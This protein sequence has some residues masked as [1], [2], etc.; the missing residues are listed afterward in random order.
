MP[1]RLAQ[2]CETFR[3]RGPKVALEA[4]EQDFSSELSSLS[5]SL[6]SNGP[7][8]FHGTLDNVGKR[9]ESESS[10][11]QSAPPSWL[12]F[13]VPIDSEL[14][15]YR[16]NTYRFCSRKA[17]L[18]FWNHLALGETDAVRRFCRDVFKVPGTAGIAFE[19]FAHFVLTRTEHNTFRWKQYDD[20]PEDSKNSE[21]SAD[22]V[23]L[24]RCL[25]QKCG[26]KNN[27]DSFEAAIKDCIS[28][29]KSVVID[30]IS[31]QQDAIDMFVVCKLDR[32]GWCVLAM[33]DTISKTHSFHP[34]KILEYR[35]AAEKAF[36]AAKQEVRDDFFLHVVV[37]PEENVGKPFRLQGA[38]MTK[39]AE[40]ADLDAKSQEL[41]LTAPGKMVNLTLKEARDACQTARIK[42]LSKLSNNQL[43]MAGAEA[44]L[45]KAAGDKVKGL[46]WVLDGFFK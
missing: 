14:G 42:G 40:V 38:T 45:L 12:V 1:R 23:V 9:G 26:M 16:S 44:S 2:Y 5:S 41:G 31:D 35:Q 6:I 33:Q 43:K 34:L 7:L 39:V 32:R 36:V 28:E 37:V 18:G 17:E 20:K 4:S 8:S 19:R 22:S 29:S 13:P 11:R 30:P 15:L 3:S 10:S 25:D 24:P 21:D 46:T 27:L